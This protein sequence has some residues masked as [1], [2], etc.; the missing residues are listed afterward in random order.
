MA[1][2][3][4]LMSIGQFSSLSRLSVRMLRHYDTH[5]V[6]VPDEVD[7]WTGR[8][9]YATTQL[10]DAATIRNLRDVGFGVSALAPL[11]AARNTPAWPNALRLQRLSLA[12]D[13][14]AAQGRLTLIDRLLD[15]GEQAV[16]I[17]IS[18]STIPDMRIVTLRGTVPT[19]ADEGLLW[20]RMMPILQSRSI[21]P[22]GRCG[23]IEHDDEYTERDVDLSIFCPVAPSTEVDAPLEV[24]DLPARDC[25]V[26]LVHGPYDRIGEA[27]DLLNS[28][29]VAEK[30][31]FSADTSLAGRSFNRYL[32]MA[33]GDP[34]QA[35]TEV[36]QPLG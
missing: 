15:Q 26:A 8:R 34:D 16:P 12:E 27:H 19:Y 22:T 18:R 25:L 20:D 32:A 31:S 33:D 17:T 10:A 14:R 23:V 35:I 30:L 13:L 11:L 36:H 29:V 28:V 6:L 4:N 1:E 2:T 9:R 5:G 3:T 7:P 24:V 21:V